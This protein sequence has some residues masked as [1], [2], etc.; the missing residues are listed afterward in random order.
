LGQIQHLR[1]DYLGAER[2]LRENLSLHPGRSGTIYIASCGWLAWGL[3]ERGEFAAAHTHLD[4]VH[5]AAEVSRHA[6]SQAIAWAMTGLVAL[7]SGDL[8]RA[9]LPLGKSL[10]TSRRKN[11]T[12]WQ[13]I[14][15][16]LL[17]LTLVRMGHVADGLRLL[18][19]SVALSRKLGVRAYLVAWMLN[20]AEGYLADRQFSRAAATAHEA[21]ELAH[22]GGE[23]AHQAHAQQL[24]GEIA[25]R[26]DPPAATEALRC[27]EAAWSL[28]E[29]LGLRPLI[30]LVHSGLQRVHA[31]LGDAA[32]V[33][34]HAAAAD[35]LTAEL[36]LRP[37]W[38]FADDGHRDASRVFV[39]A[40]S[41]EEL[42]ELLAD[43]FAGARN[44]D[45]ILDRRHAER[46][47][48]ASSAT[49]SERRHH[50]RRQATLDDDLRDWQLAV[51]VRKND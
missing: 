26:S 32:R 3:A 22:A 41:D 12:L 47:R 18:E 42:Y 15:S 45:V 44:I 24:L 14:P 9:V 38:K 25:G 34:Q 33:Q 8:T 27:Y 37:W 36:G 30:A 4:A 6:Y 35:G 17:G 48:H 21:L 28:A 46:R 50:Q 2:I 20:L 1:G 51:T 5:R 39:V 19:D 13:P 31:L 23:R 11:L 10:A 29:T 43:D 40:R 7:R 49:A 16:S